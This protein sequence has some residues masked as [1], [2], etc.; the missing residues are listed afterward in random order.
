[1]ITTKQRSYLRSLANKMDAIFQIGKDGLNDN[2]LKQ[3]DDALEARE[4]IKISVLK[5]SFYTAKEASSEICEKLN[6]EGI[7]CIGS[8]VVLYRKSKKKPKIELPQ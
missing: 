2:L 8:K 1:M 3:I 7:Q 5:N 4:L 6:C